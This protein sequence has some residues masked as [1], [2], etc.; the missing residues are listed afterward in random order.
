MAT[1]RKKKSVFLQ[2]Q[3][4]NKY[5][6]MSAQVGYISQ[7]VGPVVDVVFQH[8]DASEQLPAIHDALEVTRPNGKRLILEIQQHIGENTVRA[9]LL[10][11]VLR[12]KMYAL[13]LD[14]YAAEQAARTIAMQVATDNTN[15]LL[16]IIG[17]AQ[18]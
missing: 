5:A 17:G 16:D 11:K 12:L 4:H 10:P 18:Q 15:E 3:N 9:E 2:F 1:N 13:L 14:S 7:I 6:I 8:A